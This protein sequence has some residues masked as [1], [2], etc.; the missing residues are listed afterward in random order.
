MKFQLTIPKAIAAA[1]KIQPINSILDHGCGK[2]VSHCS[3]Q[4]T[5]VIGEVHG[6]D[7][8]VKE[9]E[10]YPSSNYDLVTSIDVLSI[11]GAY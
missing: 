4:D 5:S 3:Q 11:W 7:P 8:A 2:G 6:Y 9:F 10:R 1:Q